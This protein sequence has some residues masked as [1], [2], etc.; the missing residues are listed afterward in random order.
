MP[1]KFAADY[2]SQ[3]AAAGGLLLTEATNISRDAQGYPNTPGLYTQAQVDAWKPIVAAV[4]AA[5]PGAAFFAQLWHTGRVAHNAY[6]ENGGAPY[7]PSAIMCPS[8]GGV[9]LPDYSTV[10]YVQPREMTKAD[11]DKTIADYVTAAQNALAAGFD[12]VEFHSAN[13]YLAEQ[14]LRASSN[15]RTDEY[16]PSGGPH[17]RATFSLRVVSAL[18]NAIGADRVGI[19]LSPRGRFLI[20]APDVEVDHAT[21][22][23]LVKSLASAP[24]PIAYIHMIEPRMCLGNEES[25][26]SPSHASL[27]RWRALWGGRVFIAAG[28][29]N[30][31][32]ALTHCAA[33]PANEL[34]SIGRWWLSTPDLPARFAAEGEEGAPLN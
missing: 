11:I 26:L 18:V 22:D 8:E 33:H 28:G 19:R 15:Q 34:V 9:M 16:G 5:H 12:G 7:G 30:R 10:P 4:K 23:V 27:D 6:M 2:Y 31:A 21:C 17:G 20:D 3:R 32:R 24:S 25:T 14:F 13:G 29:F 1:P